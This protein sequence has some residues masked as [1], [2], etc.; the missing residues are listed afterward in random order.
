M[1]QQGF[2]EMLEKI[3][4]NMPM[5]FSTIIKLTLVSRV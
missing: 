4:P 1:D 2:N 3:K 5:V